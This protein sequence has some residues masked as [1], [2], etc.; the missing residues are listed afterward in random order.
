MTAQLPT[1][2]ATD[3]NYGDATDLVVVDVD[4]WTDANWEAVEHASD[5]ERAQVA[6]NI[7]PVV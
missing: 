2:F 5:S 3:G 4:H 7:G 1:Y 6:R